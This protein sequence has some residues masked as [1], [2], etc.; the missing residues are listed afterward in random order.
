MHIWIAWPLSLKIF[1]LPCIP[2][3]FCSNAHAGV[4]SSLTY[5]SLRSRHYYTMCHINLQSRKKKQ[6][7]SAAIRAT[8]SAAGLKTAQPV[9]IFYSAYPC[10]PSNLIIIIN[11]SADITPSQIKP[12]L[13]KETGSIPSLWLRTLPISYLPGSFYIHPH[14]N[15]ILNLTQ[16]PF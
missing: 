1:H 10:P 11:I 7:I 12:F 8:H 15:W 4:F 6:G 16:V 2:Y 13:K 9:P 3:I 5:H 14:V